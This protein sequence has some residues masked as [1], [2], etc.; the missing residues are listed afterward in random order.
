MRRHAAAAAVFVLFLATSTQTAEPG[1]K[2]DPSL[3][4]ALPARNIGPAN[5]GG[6]IVDLAV[7]ESDPKTIYIA[8]ATGG[9]WKTIDGGDSWKPLFDE[10][11][12]LC[13]GAVA[14]SQ[15][16]PNVVWVGSG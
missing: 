10:Q 8:P 16:A 6:R 12:T 4:A 15:S 13:L 1:A 14:V 5:M 9:L 7:V 2:P 11:A 3:F